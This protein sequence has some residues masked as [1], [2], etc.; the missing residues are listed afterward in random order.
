MS[1]LAPGEIISTSDLDGIFADPDYSQ[2]QDFFESDN[3]SDAS[4]YLTGD[5]GESDDDQQKR[6]SRT[7]SQ[8]V[9]YKESSDNEDT[10]SDNGSE[11]SGNLARNYIAFGAFDSSYI[12][13]THQEAMECS[14]SKYWKEAELKELESLKLKETFGKSGSVEK[15]VKSRWVYAKNV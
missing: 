13:N 14:E 12:P 6:P 9:R 2:G 15:G 5:E 1:P 11:Y 8:N 7:A 10:E 3:E 4:V